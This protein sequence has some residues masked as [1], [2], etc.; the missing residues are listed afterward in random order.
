MLRVL[1]QIGKMQVQLVHGWGAS[2]QRLMAPSNLCISLRSSSQIAGSFPLHRMHAPECRRDTMRPIAT[3]A[4]ESQHCVTNAL[5]R[6][7]AAS[8]RQLPLR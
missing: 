8:N 4:G 5:R 6:I 2:A 7:L 1:R 3:T